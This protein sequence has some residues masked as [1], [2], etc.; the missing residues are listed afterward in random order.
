[1]WIPLHKFSVTT[2]PPCFSQ[3]HWLPRE[4]SA[5]IRVNLQW[6]SPLHPLCH[7]QKEPPSGNSPS[8]GK[9]NKKPIFKKD[10]FYPKPILKKDNFCPKPIFLKASFGGCTR[11]FRGEGKRGK[12]VGQS[13]DY[14]SSSSKSSSSSSSSSSKSSSSSSSSSSSASSSKSSSSFSS[15]HPHS[16]WGSMTIAPSR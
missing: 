3:P 7:S 8:K 16:S 5:E 10:N 1:M 13:L 11:R 12:G 6:L 9:F 4:I 2:A 15:S 14:S